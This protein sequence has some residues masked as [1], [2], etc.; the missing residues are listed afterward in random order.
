MFFF[1]IEKLQQKH[2]P[3]TGVTSTNTCNSLQIQWLFNYWSII[4]VN[5]KLPVIDIWIWYAPTMLSLPFKEI[6]RFSFM[7]CHVKLTLLVKSES[8]NKHMFSIFLDSPMSRFKKIPF[9]L[10][11]FHYQIAWFTITNSKH[12]CGTI[13]CMP[14]WLQHFVLITRYRGIKWLVMYTYTRTPHYYREL[15]FVILNFGQKSLLYTYR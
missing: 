15:H 2:W 14:H 11:L 6:R 3:W 4:T 7:I 9:K 13:L 1:F 10:R 12:N 8:V 5:L